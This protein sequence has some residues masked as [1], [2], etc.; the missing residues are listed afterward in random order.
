MMYKKR[1][2]WKSEKL[3]ESLSVGAVQHDFSW[4]LAIRCGAGCSIAEKQLLNARGKVF[5]CGVECLNAMLQEAIERFYQVVLLWIINRS[6]LLLNVSRS[7]EISE[8]LRFELTTVVA[9]DDGRV[10]KSS[11][12]F[13]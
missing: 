6:A 12:D 9:D 10:A 8:F 1:W 4:A 3:A 7:E 13:C 2:L 5:F 11:K